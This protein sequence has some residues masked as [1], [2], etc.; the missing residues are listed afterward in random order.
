MSKF[1]ACHKAASTLNV[2]IRAK[3]SNLLEQLL[4]EFALAF[5]FIFCSLRL[6]K[7]LAD[8]VAVLI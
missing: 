6:V 2:S 5:L 8:G 1:V 7:Y 3:I 4:R